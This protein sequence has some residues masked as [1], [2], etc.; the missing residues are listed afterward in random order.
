MWQ[1]VNADMKTKIETMNKMIVKKGRGKLMRPRSKVEG[2]DENRKDEETGKEKEKKKN[3]GKRKDD[4][5]METRKRRGRRKQ[6][7]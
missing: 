3:E 1:D 6:K 7:G 5:A 2:K 4:N